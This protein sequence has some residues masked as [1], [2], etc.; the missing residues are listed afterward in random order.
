MCEKLFAQALKGL[1]LLIVSTQL[2][3]FNSSCLARVSKNANI[4]VHVGEFK[5]SILMVWSGMEPAS[6]QAQKRR[7]PNELITNPLARLNVIK[8]PAVYSYNEQFPGGGWRAKTGINPS[9]CNGRRTNNFKFS[10]A[11]H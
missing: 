3:L 9:F 11:T 10:F 2:L 5:F 1:T 7:E 6:Q 8:A 4:G